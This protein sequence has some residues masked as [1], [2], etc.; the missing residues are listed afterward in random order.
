[1][2]LVDH[3]VALPKIPGVPASSTFEF[4][5]NWKTPFA[6]AL[7]YAISVHMLNPSAAQA[8]V[9]RVKA[10]KQ[11]NGKLSKSG[12]LLTTLILLHNLFLAAYSVLTFVVMVP[13][14]HKLFHRGQS[15]HDA[16]CDN[17]GFFWNHALGYWG[18]L[19]YLSKY[20]EL[21]DTVIILL[22]GHHCSL[23][24][25]FHHAGAII[26]MWAGIRYSA[27]PTW[28]VVVYNSLIHVVMYTYFLLTSVGFHVPGK[29][30]ITSMQIS[31]LVVGMATAA[32]YIFKEQC[33]EGPGRLYLSLIITTYLTPLTYL[34]WDFARQSYGKGFSGLSGKKST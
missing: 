32:P 13:A 1:M 29:Q 33:F 24:Q 28:I 16:Y 18:Y 30:Y 6:T 20:Y 5:M 11:L 10:K 27:H 25:I 19:F 22:K 9:S 4:F 34:F 26:T 12:P 7:I 15:L 17:D 2:S 31:Q 21:L 14:L 8:K 3:S 23:L